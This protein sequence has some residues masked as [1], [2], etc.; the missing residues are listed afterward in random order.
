MRKLAALAAVVTMSAGVLTA[1]SGGDYCGDLKGYVDSAKDVDIKNADQVGK[2]L[3]QA[4]KVSK[5]APD[6]LKDDWKTVI[7]YA[8]KAQDAKGDTNK[9]VEL[10][11]A[12]GDKITPAMQAITKQAKDT[13]K[14]D[15]PGA[16]NTN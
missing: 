6:D 11:K 14:I 7:D 3:D 4:K 9:L 5:S 16:G 10:A 1:C 8:E 15:L 2:M 12:D 13:C